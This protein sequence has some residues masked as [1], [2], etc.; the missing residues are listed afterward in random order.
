[1]RIDTI[2][3]DGFGA[4]SD[5]H[6]ELN[7]PLTLFYGANEAGKSTTMAFIRAVLFGFPS[8][9][10]LAGRY[11][12]ARG[13]AH[14][15]WLV[16]ADG[17]GRRLRAARY[18]GTA[19][20]RSASGGVVTLAGFGGAEGAPAYE[21]AAHA[22]EAA[23]GE[24]R[25]WLGGISPELYRSLFAFGLS[26]L[27][28]LSTLQSEEIS[29]YLYSAGWGASGRAIAAAERK[30]LQEMERLYKRKGQ[31]PELNRTLKRIEELNAELRRTRE[32]T[33]RY[34]DMV[35]Q[36]KS[37][38]ERIRV[39]EEELQRMRDSE[40]FQERAL[41]CVEPYVRYRELVAE[42]AELPRFEAFPQ[43]AL[44]RFEVLKREQA[45]E[46]AARD[47]VK[48]QVTRLEELM[49]ANVPNLEVL[50]HRKEREALVE[51]A[52]EYMA[53]QSAL[54]E[55]RLERTNRDRELRQLLQEIDEGWSEDELLA[56]PVTVAE[57]EKVREAQS[58]WEACRTELAKLTGEK[59]RLLRQLSSAEQT[60]RDQAERLEAARGSRS[61]TSKLSEP[62]QEQ[63]EQLVQLSEHWKE[64]QAEWQLAVRRSEDAQ[65]Y[66]AERSRTEQQHRLRQ[67]KLRAQLYAALTGMVT[68]VLA[69][70]FMYAGKP[71]IAVAS[72]IAGVAALV[73]LLWPKQERRHRPHT[74][75]GRTLSRQS[76]GGASTAEAAESGLSDVTQATE[77]AARR[78]YTIELEWMQAAQPVLEL[79]QIA[80]ARDA[81]V[82][83]A[84]SSYEP[85]L[86]AEVLREGL[87]GVEGW[88]SSASVREQEEQRLR[89]CEAACEALRLQLQQLEE[90][91]RRA[92]GRR[93]ELRSD[94]QRWLE[95]LRLPLHVSP[96][97][98]ADVFRLAEQGKRILSERTAID[99]RI[100][101]KVSLIERYRQEAARWF[102]EEV[103]KDD[104][105]RSIRAWQEEAAKQTARVQAYAEWQSEL[106][107]HQDELILLEEKLRRNQESI[108]LI[109]REAGAKE[110]E[111]F[112][113]NAHD[114]ARYTVIRG[115]LNELEAWFDTLAGQGG[116]DK[117]LELL[118][119]RDEASL[120]EAVQQCKEQIKHAEQQLA[121][122]REQRG[123]LTG[124][125]AQLE[126]GEEH[127]DRL[128]KLE[129]ARS[130][131]HD[132]IR[133]WGT[134]AMTAALFRSSKERYERERQPAV[135]RRASEHIQVLTD[136]R[137]ARVIAPI[138]SNR[139]QV[140]RSDGD[141]M[142]PAYLSRGTAEQLYLAVRLAL[143]EEYARTKKPL[144]L[145]LDDVFV[146][147]DRERLSHALTVLSEVSK[148]HQILLF[149]CHSYFKD[150]VQELIPHQQTL[151][152]DSYESAH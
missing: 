8:R 91:E 9:Q 33:S 42:L 12:P 88:R 145:V 56:F 134:M 131:L 84:W 110:E 121:G 77:R 112:R 36:L 27:Q 72:A 59:E 124:D 23:E 89:E 148:R 138:G 135:L 20:G 26:E 151:L 74:A 132:Q 34:S 114:H 139:I 142:D 78:L 31:N 45:L 122:S 52:A 108:A 136:G 101:H 113:R 120:Q 11:E 99:M 130:A 19:G 116:R 117:L 137:Y 43:D 53:D 100:A 62:S 129:E 60:L 75:R 147:F 150:A 125:I 102:G 4:L 90:A 87:R 104:L 70:I 94:W 55:L 81:S 58:A 48:L 83:E 47:R 44:P 86:S 32:Q 24:L 13:G 30:L 46:Q 41:R 98:A 39:E 28:E 50:S 128:Q 97:T 54:E 85:L 146:N 7:G 1:M 14:G 79:R 95:Q 103:L 69:G 76:L 67:S 126:E 51:Q 64:A 68:A 49:A 37:L 152:L 82:P 109:W 107:T 71:A 6:Y 93:D 40:A 10:N 65:R 144:P 115:E 106:G 66:E 119:S 63:L 21:P 25:S 118:S 92:E 3:I 57:R 15:G 38:D 140:Q 105:I 133:K 22:G 127:A 17:D 61:K 29:G 111:A 5:R 149:T 80:S 73:W 35:L 16:L 123:K 2:H 96:G 141:L 18:A 143:V